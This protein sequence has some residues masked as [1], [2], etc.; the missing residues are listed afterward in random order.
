[1]N[2]LFYLLLMLVLCLQ[3]SSQ[4]KVYFAGKAGAWGFM[5]EDHITYKN[6][7][8]YWGK[9]EYGIDFDKYTSYVRDIVKK[10]S[11][12][13]D[14]IREYYIEGWK[15]EFS[16]FTDIKPGTKFYI[17]SEDNVVEAK[18]TGYYIN[19]DDEIYGGVM[20]YPMA[21]YSGGVPEYSVLV[22]SE[23][24]KIGKTVNKSIKDKGIIKDIKSAL[25]PLVKGI[26]YTEWE[27]GKEIRHKVK[28][29]ADDEITVFKL[30]SKKQD[31]EYLVSYTKRLNFDNFASFIF[32][33]D[34]DGEIKTKLSD[35]TSGFTYSK[36]IGI[37]D[38]DGDGM[39]EII[40][41]SGYYEGAGFELWK[42]TKDGY[43]PVANGFNWGV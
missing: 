6:N 8:D 3:A 23:S 39:Y 30:H 2:K 18:V 29:I 15:D 7:I 19:L 43:I 21:Y 1:M 36:S 31:E 33:T 24:K 13:N 35:L 32:I 4:E 5:I 25:L 16:H 38:T 22:C 17:S 9:S 42:K 27:E 11:S 34:E 14:T 26:T 28:S 37:V 12:Y 40:I 41:E 20:L 10:Y